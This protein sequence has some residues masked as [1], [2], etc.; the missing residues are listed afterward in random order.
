MAFITRMVK[1]D[2]T[3]AIKRLTTISVTSET[4]VSSS[5]TYRPPSIVH[6]LPKGW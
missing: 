2:K 6:P 4:V 3:D 5:Q 1:E